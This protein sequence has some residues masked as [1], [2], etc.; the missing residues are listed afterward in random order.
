MQGSLDRETLQTNQWREDMTELSK[1][2][3]E[4]FEKEVLEVIAK[5]HGLFHPEWRKQFV[6][7]SGNVEWFYSPELCALINKDIDALVEKSERSKR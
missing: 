7:L 5:Y 1:E 2:A 4:Y 3:Q 6:S